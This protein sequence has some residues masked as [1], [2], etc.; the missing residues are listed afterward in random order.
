MK[1]LSYKLLLHKTVELYVTVRGHLYASNLMEKHKQ[2]M[3]K[4]IQRAKDLRRELHD[5]NN[6]ISIRICM[7]ATYCIFFD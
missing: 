5:T 4:G 2:A 3:A 6:H 1:R 7:V